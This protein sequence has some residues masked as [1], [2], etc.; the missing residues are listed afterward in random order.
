MT[1][2]L[3]E[4]IVAIHRS[5]DAAELPHAFGGALALAWC[6]EE[7][8][9]TFDIDVNIFVSVEDAPRALAALPR[10]ISHDMTNRSRLERDGQDRL[11][12]GRI[13]VDLFLSNTEY[14][15]LVEGQIVL[16]PFG[17]L[18]VPFLGCQS[19]ATF[20]AFFD[21][22]KDWIDLA[23]MIATGRVEGDVLRSDLIRFLGDDDPRLQKLDEILRRR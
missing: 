11:W 22:D 19:L 8:R 18:D 2:S 23:S 9:A 17:G 7:P 3:N 20:K 13:A 4:A 10:G 6:T 15:D 16:H 5:L 14:H 21:R 12:W 1:V